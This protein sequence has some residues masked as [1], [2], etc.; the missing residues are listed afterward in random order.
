MQT[1]GFPMALAVLL[2]VLAV[3]DV[4][5]SG[6]YCH[7]W[8]DPQGAWRDGFQCPERYDAAEA[9]ICCGKCELRYCCSSTEARLDQGTCDNDK[10]GKEEPGA[11]HEE[12]KN[13]GAVP[14]YV[15][16]LI[17]GS[18]F[19]AF[20]LLG[21][22]VAVCCCRCL[23]PKQEPASG[24][25]RL[26]E[27]IPMM[28]SRGSSSR[29]SSTATSSSS[30]APPAATRPIPGPAPAPILRTQASCCLPPDASV[31]VNMPTNFSVLNCQQATQIMPHQGQFL[32]PQYIGYA[33]P[34]SPTPA[35]L[36]PTQGAYRALHSPFPPPTSLTS[37]TSVTSVSGDQ[38]QPS[39][40]I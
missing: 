24:G 16:F 27:S 38:K 22:V 28:T 3:M 5:A 39:V 10:R 30:S 26:L 17:V 19:V 6:E 35:F 23:R 7:G 29:Q 11:G 21:S 2:T 37:V 31:Y 20:V 15:P 34:V 4:K 33:H 8:R 1:A 14:I 36:D 40:T 25:G 9:I 13:S 12:G 18:V 32:H